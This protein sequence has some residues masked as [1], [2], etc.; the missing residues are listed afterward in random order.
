M[1][2]LQS[3]RP[4]VILAG[5]GL[6]GLGAAEASAAAVQV[7]AP[8]PG[9]VS[10]FQAAGSAG[11]ARNPDRWFTLSEAPEEAVWTKWA[12]QRITFEADLGEEEAEWMLGITGK[13]FDE[14]SEILPPDFEAFRVRMK[15]RGEGS[16]GVAEIPA[17]DTLWATTWV[18]LGA[19]AGELELELRWLND[20]WT[21]GQYDANFAL[22]G[23]TFARAVGSAAQSV[24]G[25]ATSALLGVALALGGRRRRREVS[26]SASPR[27]RR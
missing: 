20:S 16:L 2:M 23:L 27:A 26:G 17:S 15:A 7:E 4:M 1:M 21:P 11:D 24:P 8:P 6:L 19:R 10:V 5:L 14:G 9:Y 22:G 18:D 12:N 25:G 3:E 13:N